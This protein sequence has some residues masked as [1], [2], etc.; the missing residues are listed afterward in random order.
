MELLLSVVY[1]VINLY[2]AMKLQ[3][4]KTKNV[5]DMSGK[6]LVGLSG[7]K[8]QLLMKD[9]LITLYNNRS[10]CTE[11]AS[12]VVLKSYPVEVG[13]EQERTNKNINI[14]R[15]RVKLFSFFFFVGTYW[16]GSATN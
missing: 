1:P 3:R 2:V 11:S 6:K 7:D 10:V 14:S 5:I 9:R 13:S 4:L 12:L 8:M 15:D 16:L